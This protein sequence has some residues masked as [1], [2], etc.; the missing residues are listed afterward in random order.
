MF[1]KYHWIWL[2]W[3]W[4]QQLISK[5]LVCYENILVRFLVKASRSKLCLRN[6]PWQDT[7]KDL[8][9]YSLTRLNSSCQFN[10]CT[11][12]AVNPQNYI[13][14]LYGEYFI[15]GYENVTNMH[16][17]Q[18]RLYIL[19]FLDVAKKYASSPKHVSYLQSCNLI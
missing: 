12:Y 14:M 11:F 6:A 5:L 13:Y 4:C 19:H 1:R 18:K 16:V 15:I 9:I 2:F 7:G 8:I 3:K 10:L 17:V